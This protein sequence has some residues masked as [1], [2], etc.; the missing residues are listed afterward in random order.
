MKFLLPALACLLIGAHAQA[1]SAALPT[2]A[3]ESV[4]KS[5]VVEF[6]GGSWTFYGPSLTASPSAVFATL[7]APPPQAQGEVIV[8]MNRGTNETA[9][10]ELVRFS[11]AIRDISYHNQT[12]WVLLS[13]HLSALNPATGQVLY[14]VPTVPA[15]TKIDND[16]RAYAFAWIGEHLVIAHGTRGMMVFDPAARAITMAHSLNLIQPDGRRSKA[17]SVVAVNDHQ[18]VFA[19]ENVTVSR[20]APFAFDG[21]MLM[22][23]NGSKFLKNF[24]YDRRNAGVLANARLGFA[25]G[26]VLINDWGTLQHISVKALDKEGAIVVGWTPVHFNIGGKSVPAELSG[27]L[28]TDGGQVTACAHAHSQENDSSKAGYLGLLYQTSESLAPHIKK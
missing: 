6:G 1:Q 2:S 25:D 22:D 11:Q 15:G 4:C 7:F 20:Q 24:P 5:A 13:D 14:S 28:L 19:I 16:N 10:V 26:Q 12:L 23:L 9:P 21:L 27:D 8:K 3:L 17:E 18:A